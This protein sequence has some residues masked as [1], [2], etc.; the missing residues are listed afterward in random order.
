MSVKDFI[1]AAKSF[2]ENAKRMLD[3]KSVLAEHSINRCRSA[4]F[5][6][7]GLVEGSHQ[8]SFNASSGLR[9]VLFCSSVARKKWA[10]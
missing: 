5:G 3:A 2:F 7:N 4:V 6:R 10:D 9:N 8:L 1:N